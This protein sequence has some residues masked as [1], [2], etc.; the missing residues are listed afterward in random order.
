MEGKA[1]QF[2]RDWMGLDVCNCLDD[3]AMPFSDNMYQIS[4]CSALKTEAMQ[5][6]TPPVS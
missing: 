4:T 6:K 2:Y 3:W 1:V 5:R